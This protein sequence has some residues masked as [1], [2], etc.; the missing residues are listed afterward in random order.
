MNLSLTLPT[1]RFQDCF[2]RFI[3]QAKAVW[4]R[5]AL[6]AQQSLRA[7]LRF[8]SDIVDDA[9]RIAVELLFADRMAVRRMFLAEPRSDHS[10]FTKD[11]R[12][13]LARWA[14]HAHALAPVQTNDPIQMARAEGKRELF[15]MIVADLLEDL[16][17]FARLMAQEEARRQ[18]EI[19][20]A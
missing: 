15:A 20:P 6:F 3:P 5:G 1:Q 7:L 4:A 16:P 9:A 2:G 12:R 14:R 10:D 8:A 17:D 18:E 19:V 13:T 11:G